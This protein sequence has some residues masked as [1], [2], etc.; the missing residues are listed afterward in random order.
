MILELKYLDVLILGDGEAESE[1]PTRGKKR[2][3]DGPEAD[4]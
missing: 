3:H 1:S 4:V 2:K